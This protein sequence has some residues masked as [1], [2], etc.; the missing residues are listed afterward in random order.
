MT[1]SRATLA[2]IISHYHARASL[3][4]VS[5]LSQQ[6]ASRRHRRRPNGD[7][8]DRRITPT[9]G[10]T[11]RPRKLSSRRCRPACI[12]RAWFCSLA[13]FALLALALSSCKVA[14][15]ESGDDQVDPAIA[16]Q[17][18]LCIDVCSKLLCNPAVDPGPDFE[19]ECEATCTDAVAVAQGDDCTERYQSL[20]ECANELPCDD[21]SSW[22]GKELTET[23]PA[24]AQEVELNCPNLPP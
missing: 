19:A 17:I 8:I 6:R 22:W 14:D 4:N 13:R 5:S 21:Y 16:A 1:T 15:D 2:T 11:W 9:R 23:C 18:E 12:V 24:E 3:A 20:L 7:A 10:F